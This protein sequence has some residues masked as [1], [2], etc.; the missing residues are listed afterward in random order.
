MKVSGKKLTCILGFVDLRLFNSYGLYY[1]VRVTIYHIRITR[2]KFL[3]R[4][5]S[6]FVHFKFVV[7]T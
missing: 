4:N 5:I 3:K 7:F 1:D 2:A 6:L